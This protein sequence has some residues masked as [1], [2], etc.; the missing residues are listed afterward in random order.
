MKIFHPVQQ[1]QP[2][3]RSMAEPVILKAYEVYTYVYGEQPAMIDVAKG[4]RGG[5]SARELIAF[6]YARSFPR[7]EWAYRVNEAFER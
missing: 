6:L 4:C 1:D 7:Q 5:F 3:I 2:P